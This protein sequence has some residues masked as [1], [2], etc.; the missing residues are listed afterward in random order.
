MSK[1]DE[2]PQLAKMKEEPSACKHEATKLNQLNTKIDK[3]S[4]CAIKY[5]ISIR[6][7][8]VSLSRKSYQFYQQLVANTEQ[9]LK[10]FL[11][12]GIT[13]FNHPK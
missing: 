6:D 5:K 11:V 13:L 7:H 9:E 12:K 8:E 3:N 2:L 4:S 1:V 10:K